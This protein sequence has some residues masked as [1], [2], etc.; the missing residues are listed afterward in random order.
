MKEVTEA[1]TRMLEKDIEEYCKIIQEYIIFIQ[2]ESNVTIKNY[3]MYLYIK[4]LLKE[5]MLTTM[6]TYSSINKIQQLEDKYC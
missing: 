6:Q 4:L 3:D 1:D 2:N 5:S